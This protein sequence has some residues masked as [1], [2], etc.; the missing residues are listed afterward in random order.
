MLGGPVLYI[1]GV[2]V[3]FRWKGLMAHV[4]CCSMQALWV[5]QSLRAGGQVRWQARESGT[6]VLLITMT[7]SKYSSALPT[8]F[9][10]FVRTSHVYII[11]LWFPMWTG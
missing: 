4:V 5:F 3:R 2:R 10:S 7:Y 6:A 1:Y 9:V 8:E 11:V